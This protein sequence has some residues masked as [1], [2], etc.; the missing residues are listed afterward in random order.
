M[1]AL[2][3]IYRCVSKYLFCDEQLL[4]EPV[5]LLIDDDY[6]QPNYRD[7]AGIDLFCMDDGMMESFETKLIKTKHKIFLPIG[8]YAT[9][10]PRSSTALQGITIH[11]TVIDSGYTGD[12]F[13][14]A[15]SNRPVH[16]FA[17]KSND[18]LAQIVIRKKIEAKLNLLSKKNFNKLARETTLYD[19]LNNIKNRLF[20]MDK[21]H[22]IERVLNHDLSDLPIERILESKNPIYEL[23]K[24]EE[25][26]LLSKVSSK[27]VN[28]ATNIDLLKINSLICVCVGVANR[29]ES[30]Q[31]NMQLNCVTPYEVRQFYQQYY[32]ELGYDVNAIANRK[33]ADDVVVKGGYVKEPLCGEHSN[34][35]VLDMDAMYPS[36]MIAFNLGPLTSSLV[37][38]SEAIDFENNHVIRIDANNFVV[39]L[40]KPL[41][42]LAAT[43]KYLLQQRRDAN[44]ASQKK[45]YK[46]MSN[47]AYG[48]AAKNDTLFGGKQ[49]AA[50]VT[51]YARF[52]MK[53]LE[54]E[55]SQLGY[56]VLYVD[57]DSLFLGGKRFDRDL[58][59]LLLREALPYDLL[60]Y[61][62][63]K[64]EAQYS[65]FSQMKRKQYTAIIADNQVKV[66]KGN[67]SKSTIYVSKKCWSV[68]CK[69]SYIK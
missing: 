51:Q 20:L 13:I 3:N 62:H 19:F 22:V 53:A 38:T 26:K 52:I 69:P 48:L 28:E 44:N 4:G 1:E 45:M 24:A 14:I 42:P 56:V 5:T 64:L 68:L 7:D 6:I 21:L 46:Q 60:E 30:M 31:K 32:T 59:D 36:V 2:Y 40:K 25:Y 63:L 27:K 41:G 58:P 47:M 15:S 57:T 16:S 39:S 23:T 10:H 66:K 9:V 12:I 50:A 11:S 29:C 55:A 18:R 49:V 33:Y 35:F 61:F 34:V 43:Q 8:Y 67:Y 37:A 65:T 17:Y 54:Q